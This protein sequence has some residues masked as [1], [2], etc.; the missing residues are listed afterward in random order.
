MVL[1]AGDSAG[2]RAAKARERLCRTYGYLLYAFAR[3]QGHSSHDA[4][5]LTQ[6]FLRL[7]A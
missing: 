4:Q 1:A 2:P 3:R 5:D 7:A 6:G